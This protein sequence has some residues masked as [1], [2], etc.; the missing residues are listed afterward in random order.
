MHMIT[1][2]IPKLLEQNFLL[3]LLCIRMSGK[4]IN[5]DGK[6][7]YKVTFTKTKN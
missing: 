2:Y 3:F 5:F 4:S 7:I 6:K 1:P